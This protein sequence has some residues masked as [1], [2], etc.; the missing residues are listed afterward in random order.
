MWT[1]PT[2]G[3]LIEGNTPHLLEWVHRMLWPRAEG[4]F[5]T[6]TG[7][8]TDADPD[9][10]GRQAILAMDARQRAGAVG[11]QGRVQCRAWRQGLDPKAAKI[12][13]PFARHVARQIRGNHAEA[14]S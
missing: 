7:A 14:G 3:A 13:R 8:D 11:R 4:A 9:Q 2:A 10:T 6:W 5:E 1:D 12:S